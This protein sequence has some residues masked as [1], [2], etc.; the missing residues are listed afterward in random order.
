M[1][2]SSVRILHAPFLEIIIS[3]LNSSY[4][5][6]AHNSE[7]VAILDIIWKMGLFMKDTVLC[8]L[9]HEKCMILK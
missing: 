8:K 3:I 1:T 7:Q 4:M 2:L 9:K 5:L 6:P